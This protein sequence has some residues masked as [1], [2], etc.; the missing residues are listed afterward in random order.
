MWWVL[1]LVSEALACGGIFHE[2]GALAESSG[3]QAILTPGDGFVD[4][5]YRTGVQADVREFAWV[6]PAAGEVT[7]VADGEVEDFDDLFYG[8][9]PE[10]DFKSEGGGCFAGAAAKD[11]GAN[12]L[13]QGSGFTGTYDYTIL[14]A[15][16]P[17]ALLTWLDDHG[18]DVGDLDG[19]IEEYSLE[20]G[21]QFV[22]I[23]LNSGTDED[24]YAELPPIRIRHSGDSVVYPARMAWHN[25]MQELSTRLYVVG[26]QRARIS[27][28]WSETELPLVWEA[29]ESSDYV[30]GEL[31]SSEI[32]KIGEDGGF[33][34][35]YSGE[36]SGSWVT[37]YE[38]VAPASI[39]AEDVVFALDGGESEFRT[40]LSNQG[41]CN[42]P[43]QAWVLLLPLGLLARRRK[44]P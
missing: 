12:D 26:D 11:G 36:V 7:E 5:T 44:T 4:I 21:Y 24:L 19:V 1:G 3:Q 31:L 37:R 23:S 38:T 6:L 27:D 43:E 40:L 9:L 30:G 17:A 8:T 42:K 16:D 15:S 35:M 39:Y 29:G 28:G 14:D 33:A 22:A 2:D 20:E 41:G 10:E 13:E 25:N 34:L 32:S 18:F